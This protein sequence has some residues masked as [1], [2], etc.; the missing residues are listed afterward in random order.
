M[1]TRRQRAH[2]LRMSQ[3]RIGSERERRANAI[4]SGLASPGTYPT[5]AKAQA[6]ARKQGRDPARVRFDG[7][8]GRWRVG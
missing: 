2:E 6:A 8:I 3:A 7:G 1:A 4:R 5:K